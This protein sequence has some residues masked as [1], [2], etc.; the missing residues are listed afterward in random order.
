MNSLS[1]PL[2]ILWKI[3][4]NKLMKPDIVEVLRRTRIGELTWRAEPSTAHWKL[5]RNDHFWGRFFTPTLISE[6]DEYRFTLVDYP[7][8]DG[9]CCTGYCLTIRERS[10]DDII[11][12]YYN[13][14]GLGELHELVG[15]TCD[16]TK[17]GEIKH[18]RQVRWTDCNV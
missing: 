6:N 10:S 9:L 14:F 1:R 13:N 18:D 3:A 17:L 16:K 7:C 5:P 11:S 15:K 2:K 12:R 8:G 4:K